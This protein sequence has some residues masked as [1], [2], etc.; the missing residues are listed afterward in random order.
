MPHARSSTLPPSPLDSWIPEPDVRERFQKSVHAPADLVMRV[1]REFDMQSIGIVRLTFWL[2]ERL[3]RSSNRSP[4]KPQGIVD[5]LR[6]L[7][8]GVLA[9]QPGRLLV[10]GA[11]C[12]PWKADVVFRPI[13]PVQFSAFSEAGLVKIAWTFETEPAGQCETLFTH[14]TRVVATDMES[15][16][17][18]LKYWRWA[19]FGI[20]GIRFFL[21][22]AIKRDA[23][24]RWK[25]E[26]SGTVK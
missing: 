23:E 4:R 22:P 10:S 18:F 24:K 7:G 26:L 12:Q 8:W 14:E 15:R 19:R 3:M 2:R 25:R 9:D 13:D 21:M 6:A 5:E 17:R 16:A 1:A 11:A 20:I